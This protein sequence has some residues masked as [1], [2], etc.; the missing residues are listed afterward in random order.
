M[1]LSRRFL[2]SDPLEFIIKQQEPEVIL[3]Q[4]VEVGAG[5]ENF[6]E[7]TLEPTGGAPGDHRG[8]SS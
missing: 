6:M 7:L 8:G 3:T 4:R 2:D 5:D 1:V